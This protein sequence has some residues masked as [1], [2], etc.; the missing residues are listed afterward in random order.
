MKSLGRHNI[1]NS[2]GMHNSLSSLRYAQ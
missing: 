1:L 2:F